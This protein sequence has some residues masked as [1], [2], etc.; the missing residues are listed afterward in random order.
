MK[1][2]LMKR[3]KKTNVY[4]RRYYTCEPQTRDPDKSGF[5][6]GLRRGALLLFETKKKTITKI[7][8]R[9]NMMRHKTH[10]RTHTYT[11]HSFTTYT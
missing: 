6:F 9:G 1:R 3:Y 10:T 5:A 2:L 8:Y 4:G 11:H 7:S